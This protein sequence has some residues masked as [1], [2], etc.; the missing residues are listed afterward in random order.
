MKSFTRITYNTRN[1]VSQSDKTD[2]AKAQCHAVL[3]EVLLVAGDNHFAGAMITHDEV[4]FSANDDIRRAWMD[5][6]GEATFLRPKTKGQ[7]IM[8]LEFLLPFDSICLH[9]YQSRKHRL[10]NQLGLLS[11]RL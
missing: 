8:V 7:G 2:V 9:S 6:N 3:S 1:I 4:T 11:M 5:M 10:W